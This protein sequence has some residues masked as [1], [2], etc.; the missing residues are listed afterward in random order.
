[1][2]EIVEYNIGHSIIARAIFIGLT[3]AVREIVE[4]I[5]P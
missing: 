1:V 5:E 4:I 3:P 2:P